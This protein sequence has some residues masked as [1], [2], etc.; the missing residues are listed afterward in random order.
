MIDMTADFSGLE[1]LLKN[2]KKTIYVDI[3]ILGSGKVS[4]SGESVVEYGAQHEFGVISKRLPERSFIRL[5]L[6]MRQKQIMAAAQKAFT[7]NPEDI[8]GLFT[9][10]GIEGENAIKEAFQTSGFGTWAPLSENYKIRPSG[11]SVDES[12]KP[13]LDTGALR[14]SITSKVGGS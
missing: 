2:L 9:T 10:I 6:R 11:Q 14:N 1:K 5:G 4:E 13:L 7:E 12:S 3:G 8:K